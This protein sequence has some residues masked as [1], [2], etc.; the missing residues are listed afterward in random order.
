MEEIND[1]KFILETS[2]D[3]FIAE[4]GTKELTNILINNL[5][6]NDLCNVINKIVI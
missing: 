6:Y 1:V 4:Y 5:T 3:G 2:L